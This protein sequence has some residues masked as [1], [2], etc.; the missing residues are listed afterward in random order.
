LECAGISRIFAVSSGPRM[1]Y[2]KRLYG[3]W[4]DM[5]LYFARS[6][7]RLFLSESNPCEKCSVEIPVRKGRGTYGSLSPVRFMAERP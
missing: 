7:L 3:A 6:S 2:G 5:G 4:G 1:R